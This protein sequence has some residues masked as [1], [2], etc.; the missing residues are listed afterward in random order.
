MNIFAS[1]HSQTDKKI[2]NLYSADQAIVFDWDDT[3]IPSSF[4]EASGNGSLDKQDL[5][6]ILQLEPTEWKKLDHFVSK[7]LTQLGK[8][9]DL[10]IVSNA[11]LSWIKTSSS[12]LMPLT[13]GVLAEIEQKKKLISAREFFFSGILKP[14]QKEIF[15]TLP[16]WK[17]LTFALVLGTYKNIIS[18]GDSDYERRA[19]HAM[20]NPE[21]K[22]VKKNIKFL[23]SPDMELLLEQLT[24]IKSQWNTFA[25]SNEDVDLY[26]SEGID[27]LLEYE[28][29][30]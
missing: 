9:A 29:K 16:D 27:A 18:L 13:N 1:T 4:L 30:P 6:R 23:E 12:I 8:N 22:M 19:L 15:E 5:R 7:F 25:Q 28:K 3:L 21:N 11:K 26:I 2:S 10:Y 17:S 20:P 24:F 14:N